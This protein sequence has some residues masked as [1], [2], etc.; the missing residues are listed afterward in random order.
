MNKLTKVGLSAL[1]SSLAAVSAA[2]AGEMTVTGGIDMSWTSMGGGDAVSGNP[3]GMGSNLTYKGSGELD[4]GWTFDITVAMLNQDAYSN[5]NV[6]VKM[7]GLG[8]L[9]FNQGN[10]GNGIDAYD[11]KMP[12]AWEEPWGNALGTGVQLVKGI[13]AEQNIQ[14]KTPTF[15]GVTITLAAA[16]DMGAGDAA[17]KTRSKSDD[18]NGAGYDATINLN[19]SMG[20]EILSGLNMF[21]GAHVTET[22][23]DQ[24]TANPG[25]DKY[26][27]TGGITLDIGPVSLGYQASGIDLGNNTTAS[28][29]SYYKNNF[30]GIAFNINDDLSVS[31]GNHESQQGFVNP[32]DGESVLMEIE[33][34]QVSYTIGGASIRYADTEVD[35]AAYQTGS[36]QY[37]KDARI[38]SVSLAF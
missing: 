20:T 33:S 26:Q 34:Y 13:G 27:A 23:R 32:N 36:Q 14:Y 9:D 17:D 25:N 15:G 31:Y 37:D 35:N 4:N 3:I 8:E 21:V 2:N 30:Y 19:P 10:S 5:T 29:V 38:V 28:D 11:D 16:P 22:Y 12:T 18:I 24:G 1:C 6:T 7:G